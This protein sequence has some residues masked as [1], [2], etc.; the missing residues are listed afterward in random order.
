MSPTGSRWLLFTEKQANTEIDFQNT[1]IY[2]SLLGPRL[3][4]RLK[5]ST[6]NVNSDSWPCLGSW[7][8]KI[9]DRSLWLHYQTWMP[10]C[11]FMDFKEVVHNQS[12]VGLQMWNLRP[13]QWHKWTALLH[14]LVL[15][16][17]KSHSQ[18]ENSQNTSDPACTCWSRWC[19]TPLLSQ[20]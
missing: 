20:I 19:L 14:Q 2:G 3:F 11:K 13:S 4:S 10:C 15:Q 12:N 8:D 17:P 18:A 7:M 1:L 9:C 6:W 16:V 5:S